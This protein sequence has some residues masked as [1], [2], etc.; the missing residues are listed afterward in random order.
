MIKQRKIEGVVV[1]GRVEGIYNRRTEQ[2]TQR[3]REREPQLHGTS[4][5]L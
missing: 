3:E 2:E 1:Q 5:I 4:I